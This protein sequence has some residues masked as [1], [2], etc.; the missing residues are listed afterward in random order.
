M[1]RRKDGG[2]KRRVAKGMREEEG[3]ERDEEEYFEYLESLAVFIW[4][5]DVMM[6]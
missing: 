1:K 4:K 3:K 2:K 5:N 6:S